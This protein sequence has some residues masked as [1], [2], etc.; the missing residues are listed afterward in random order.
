MK[1]SSGRLVV[2][3]PAGLLTQL[4]RFRA[5]AL[6]LILANFVPVF[7]V[8]ALGWNAAAIVIFYWAENL[9]VGF[10]NILRMRRARGT[11][12]SSGMT[13][14]G[15][16]VTEASRASLIVFFAFHY[17]FFTLGHGVFVLALFGRQFAGSPRDLMI[18]ALG[19]FVSHG[20]S[21]RKNF[22]GGGEYKKVSFADLFW[23]PY[24][25][26]VVMH[27]T[28]IFGGALAGASGSPVGALI[29]MVAL[30]TLVDLASH[31]AERRKFLRMG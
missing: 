8:L 27:L 22:I 17:G 21:Y 23:Q 31:L 18:G 16:T 25:R 20:I 3:P 5:S 19:L 12:R 6:A 7:G 29:L 28:I 26:I 4:A 2:P 15:K 1:P 13:L 24:G 30:K 14:N 10:F 9:A 11:L